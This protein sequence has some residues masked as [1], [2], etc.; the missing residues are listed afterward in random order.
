M[1]AISLKMKKFYKRIECV[2]RKSDDAIKEM[3]GQMR[4]ET[5]GTKN[6]A[7]ATCA[8]STEVPPFLRTAAIEPLRSFYP[9]K[10]IP[11][12]FQLLV[13]NKH[14]VLIH[15]PQL[16]LCHNICHQVALTLNQVFARSEHP[17]I[18][19]VLDQEYTNCLVFGYA[20]HPV[21]HDDPLDVEA[22]A[23][24]VYRDAF[25]GEVDCCDIY[26]DYIFVHERLRQL[27]LPQ[28]MLLMIQML[29]NER[30][31]RHSN[32]AKILLTVNGLENESDTHGPIHRLHRLYNIM[33][34]QETTW[35]DLPGHDN[36][37]DNANVN[38]TPY[39]LDQQVNV[40]HTSFR[41]LHSRYG[42]DIRV[43]VDDNLRESTIG[44]VDFQKALSQICRSLPIEHV[45]R[46]PDPLVR[47]KLR[48][49]SFSHIENEK[50][51]K[52]QLVFVDTDITAMTLVPM[53][54][55]THACFSYMLKK[56]RG[57]GVPERSFHN[58]DMHVL[59]H[60]SIGA[61]STLSSSPPSY[62]LFCSE[63]N[64]FIIGPGHCTNINNLLNAL[65]TI[66]ALHFGFYKGCVEA[67]SLPSFLMTLEHC[68]HANGVLGDLRITEC[69]GNSK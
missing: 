14:S 32:Y 60:M 38:V 13:N 63:C 31:N 29:F 46:H 30:K 25:P 10:S 20:E 27:R 35:K 52:E 18:K 3:L 16:N 39:V 28:Y 34:F 5:S 37:Y 11:T 26:V 17:Y 9:R 24:V 21:K 62:Q 42:K 44:D 54:I 22:A 55:F 53:S 2:D 69:Q 64:D 56:P 48:V 36:H 1:E 7:T 33:G 4:K 50:N 8:A 61:S 59:Q 67:D 15:A 19:K 12:E 49:I 68:H 51:M 23:F 45:L 58:F 6:K 41:D 66:A 65:P 40:T 43:I 47:N 57:R